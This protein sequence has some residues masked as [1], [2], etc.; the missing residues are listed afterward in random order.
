MKNGEKRGHLLQVERYNN[1]LILCYGSCSCFS[2]LFVGF[3]FVTLKEIKRR[4]SKQFIHIQQPSSCNCVCEMS[5]KRKKIR[6]NLK[7]IKKKSLM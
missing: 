6:L 4:K 2:C 1:A 7:G 5:H 3:E